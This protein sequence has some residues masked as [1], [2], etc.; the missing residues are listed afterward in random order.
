MLGQVV[1]EVGLLV[2]VCALSPCCL[3]VR[4]RG[5]FSCSLPSAAGRPAAGRVQAGDAQHQVSL[6]APCALPAA[7]GRA[8][9]CQ[10]G[11]D[12]AGLSAGCFVL[13]TL[14]LLPLLLWEWPRLLACCCV[15]SLLDLCGVRPPSCL[16]LGTGTKPPALWE[17][18]A[19][20]SLHL[21]QGPWGRLRV[22]AEL[23]VTAD[24]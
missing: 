2:L 6:A 5:R 8:G 9:R 18:T 1:L 16:A 4:S 20:T 24:V 22:E 11:Q 7:C 13:C 14:P 15:L 17:D 19:G 12:L 21:Q 10:R 3:S 23:P